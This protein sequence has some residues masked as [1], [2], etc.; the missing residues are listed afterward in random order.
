MDSFFSELKRRNV[1]RVAGMYAVVG[2]ILAQ[3]ATTLEESLGLPAWFDASIVAML[4]LG[5][6]IALIFAWAFE[7]T[8]EGVVKTA[9]VPEG[10]SIAADKGPRRT[11][12]VERRLRNPAERTLKNATQHPWRCCRSQICP[13]RVTR[14]TFLMASPR[15]F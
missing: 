14:N 8:P 10:E 6:P 5:F 12:V 15:R 7:L 1:F 9:V 2:W 13:R 11:S 3:I 4:L